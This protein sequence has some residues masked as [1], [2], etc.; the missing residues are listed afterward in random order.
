MVARKFAIFGLM[1]C[2]AGIPLL[3]RQFQPPAEPPATAAPASEHAGLPVDLAPTLSDAGPEA[4]LLRIFN[5]IEANRL[6]DALQLT[7]NLLR[8]YPNY[9]LANLIKGDLLL[10]RTRPIESF[11]A[12][13]D[14]PADKIADLRAEA[15]VRLKAYR[16]RPEDRFV[17]RYL[18]QMPPDQR[19]A[20]VVDTQRSRLYLYANDRDHGGR[21]R[22][23]ADYYVTQGKLGAD[24]HAEGDKKTPIGV[25]H[26]TANLPR[27]KL[28]DLY[29]SGAFPINYPNEWDRQQGRSGGGIWLHGTPSDTFARPP[30]A[31]DGCVVLTNPDLDAVAKNLQ[32][33]LT[34]VII[35]PS[36]EWLSLDDWAKERD[37]LNAA[38][39]AWRRD[40]E[41]RDTERY[42]KHYS[43]RFKTGS[44]DFAAFAAQKT[45]VN[46]SKEWIKVGTDNLSVFR[47]PGQDEM[48]VVTFDQDY[49][50]NN[51]NNRMKKR[52]YWQRENGLWKIIYEGSA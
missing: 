46:A 33:G 51:L 21:P 16:E 29:G 44:Q 30:R 52:Q 17:P 34:P 31:S 41:S 45:Q 11:G 26:V 32:V 15:I 8:Q 27:Q 18:L 25:Y 36:V 48:V 3:H 12:L 2:L 37:E 4:Q 22:F 7:E 19:F 6:G 24:K 10:A 40:W 39:D 23:V 5:E 43:P 13:S 35:S 9:R 49:R 38:I 14:A 50:S 28:A 1:G 20:V 42:L 47:S